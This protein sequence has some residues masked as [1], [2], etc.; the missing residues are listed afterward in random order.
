MTRA[1]GAE[2]LAEIIGCDERMVLDGAGHMAM[3]ERS[4]D[5]NA[6]LVRFLSR[7]TVRA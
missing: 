6:A 7:A 2:R 3:F 4:E 5:V 1:S